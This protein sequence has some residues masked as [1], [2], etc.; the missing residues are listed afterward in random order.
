[1]KFGEYF[2]DW[3]RVI[4]KN[5]YKIILAFALFALA[6]VFAGLS[7]NYVMNADTT[8]SH[9]LILDNF[10]PVDLTF[11]FVYVWLAVLLFLLLYAVFVR[12]DKLHRVVF[13][14]SL[15][16]LV[17]S[18]F[19][20][21]THLKTPIDAIPVHFPGVLSRLAFENDMFFSGHTAFPLI[22]FF[23]FRNSK[24]RYLF[25]A[26]S[27]LLAFTVLA[28]HQHYSIDVFAAFFIAYGTFKLGEMMLSYMKRFEL[29]RR[30]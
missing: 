26:F 28:M 8:V 22:G 9:D 13:H 7:G 30:F 10:P 16:L 3:I 12:H 4:G 11:I 2:E 29:F 5:I 23:V 1:M 20:V 19:I 14:Y 21:L 6:S 15:L 17:R 18:I 24:I 27:L 25:L